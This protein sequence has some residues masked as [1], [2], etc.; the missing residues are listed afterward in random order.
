MAKK[1]AGSMWLRRDNRGYLVEVKDKD[2]YLDV[3]FQI[4]PA[5][6]PVELEPGGGPVRVRLVV[7]DKPEEPSPHSLHS[8][9]C[10][11]G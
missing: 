8:P 10:A 2:G 5:Q 4:D 11:D 1:Q 7:E 6:S 3:D 9:W